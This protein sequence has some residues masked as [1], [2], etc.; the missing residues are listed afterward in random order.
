MSTPNEKPILMRGEM[1]RAILAGQKTQTRRPI[2]APGVCFGAGGEPLSVD[3]LKVL[4][5]PYGK[6]GDRLWVRETFLDWTE[7]IYH[8][9]GRTDKP[10]VIYRADGNIL[11]NGNKWKPSIF[12]PR[13][14][15]RIALEIVSVRVQRLQDISEADATAEG[16][17]AIPSA[18]A[19]TT[20]RTAFAGLWK[21][22]HGPESWV[23]N[24]FLWVI[25][26][27]K[28]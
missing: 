21:K 28:L 23:A 15:S 18:P 13:A 20:H 5:C 10:R 4:H 6:P 26:F 8:S 12:M 27:R 22:I 16:V 1:V 7:K 24:P 2:K 25:S 14:L 9:E 19:A 17:D 11:V 3:G